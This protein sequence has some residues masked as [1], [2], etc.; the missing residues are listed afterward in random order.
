MQTVTTIGLDIAKSGFQV[1]GISLCRRPG[2]NP[3]PACAQQS[4]R[5]QV[6][7]DFKW[8][9]QLAQ[10]GMTHC[11]ASWAARLCP[12]NAFERRQVKL[13]LLIVMNARDPASAVRALARHGRQ[14]GINHDTKRTWI[15]ATAMS[16]LGPFP[17]SC[18][19]SN[20]S[21]GSSS[22]SGCT[23]ATL[24]LRTNTSSVTGSMW[25]PA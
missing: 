20:M 19:H 14:L 7:A 4:G 13:G 10:S 21:N 12:R 8:Q 11:P 15:D 9:D 25:R 16:V 3:P 2:A 6:K 23:R 1:H 17:D 24:S 18:Q 5:I 22:G